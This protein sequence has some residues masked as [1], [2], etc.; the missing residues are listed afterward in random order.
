[1]SVE[2]RKYYIDNLRWA[3]ILLLVP[4]HSAMAWNSWGEGSYIWFHAN[5]GF[6]Y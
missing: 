5:R 1:M 2:N 6:D 3:C 4:F